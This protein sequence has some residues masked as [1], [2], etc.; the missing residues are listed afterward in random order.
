[1]YHTGYLVPGMVVW[2]CPISH[3]ICVI[4]NILVGARVSRFLV[5]LCILSVGCVHF[6]KLCTRSYGAATHRFYFDLSPA[7]RVV[8]VLVHNATIKNTEVRVEGLPAVR[9]LQTAACRAVR[10]YENTSQMSSTQ[11]E[12]KPKPGKAPPRYTTIRGDGARIYSFL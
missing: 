3:L 4:R 10:T 9:K 2:S 6:D 1:M 7:D 5:Y 8:L 12:Y 11:G